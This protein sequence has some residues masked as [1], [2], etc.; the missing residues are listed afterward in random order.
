MIG[1]RPHIRDDR[2][3]T[4]IELLVVILIIGILAAI[5]VPAFI[6]QRDKGMD[7]S[8]KVSLNAARTAF[9]TFYTQEQTYVA[10][11]AQLIEI[12]PALG[13][14]PDFTVSG[15]VTTWKAS[16]RSQSGTTF[17]IEFN[18]SNMLERDCDRP[19][20][21]LCRAVADVNGNRW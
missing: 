8:V 1:S 4:L 6:S 16:A 21:G 2:G 12:E 9:A 18:G 11:A 3:F 5:A 10:T 15:T 17:S 19:G 20:T 14:A 7:T 13:S